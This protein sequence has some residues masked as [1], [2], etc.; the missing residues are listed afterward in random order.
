MKITKQIQR[1][2]KEIVEIH[3]NQCGLSCKSPMGEYYGLIEATVLAGYESTHLEDGD[4][5][6]FSL[7]ERCL[8]ELFES[9]MYDSFQGNILNPETESKQYASDF[10][11]Q[12]YIIHND[13]IISLEEL[14]PDEIITD[15]TLDEP[16]PGDD[17][18]REG[19][20]DD[21]HDDERVS[22]NIPI[23]KKEDLN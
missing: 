16:Y 10:N 3:C 17:L 19:F 23:M 12:E 5:Y 7:C 2:V 20:V 14:D 9:F 11:P 8:S 15:L 6:K 1:F 18:Y 21:G 22:D 13:G 4:S